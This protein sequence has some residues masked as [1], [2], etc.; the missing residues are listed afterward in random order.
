M[1]IF[2]FTQTVQPLGDMRSCIGMDKLTGT[3]AN[4]HIKE[5]T[6]KKKDHACC[7]PHVLCSYSEY[8]CA[9]VRTYVQF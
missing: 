3:H 5:F 9:I 2:A 7:C 4:T 1:F 6:R 8:R